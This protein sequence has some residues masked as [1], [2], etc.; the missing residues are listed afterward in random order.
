M[1]KLLAMILALG[2]TF[3]ICTSCGSSSS[4]TEDED[5]SSTVL[6]NSD[7]LLKSNNKVAKTLFTLVNSRYA[8]VIVEGGEYTEGE[9]TFDVT[10]AMETEGQDDTIK[11]EKYSE[12]AT[13]ADIEQVC[14]KALK[15]ADI[16]KAFVLSKLPTL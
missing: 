11:R 10:D 14:W 13:K 4:D 3:S 6:E 16:D 1:K 2:V 12:E 15:K 8:D 7:E 5:S 9:Y